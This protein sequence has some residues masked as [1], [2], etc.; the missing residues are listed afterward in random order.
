M[1]IFALPIQRLLFFG[2]RVSSPNWIP[3]DEQIHNIA[4]SDNNVVKE[5][6]NPY[7]GMLVISGILTIF[8]A[9]ILTKI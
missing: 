3:P 1:L 8:V 6:N 4:R 9:V 2:T 5:N 7:V